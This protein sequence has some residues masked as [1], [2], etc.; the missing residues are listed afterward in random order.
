MKKNKLHR[1]FL[2]KINNPDA[3]TLGLP[4]TDRRIDTAISILNDYGIKCIGKKDLNP[5]ID[6]SQ[7][8]S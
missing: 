7:L 4:E 2:D 5:L 3:I 8:I 6:I 1:L